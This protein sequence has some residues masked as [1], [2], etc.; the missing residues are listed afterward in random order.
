MHYSVRM[1][2]Q[3]KNRIRERSDRAEFANRLI[4]IADHIERDFDGRERERLLELVR[5]TLERHVEIS[6]NTKRAREA[7][8]QLHQDQ[9]SLL[10]LFEFITAR[11]ERETIH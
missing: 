8:H 4:E 9:Q 7:L 6:E 11:P 10:Q 1:S 5:E 3:L 2:N